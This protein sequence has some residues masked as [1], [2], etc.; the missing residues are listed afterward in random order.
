MTMMQPSTR[1]FSPHDQLRRR[2][3]IAV[4]R[5]RSGSRTHRAFTKE[6]ERL[7]ERLLAKEQDFIDN[8]AFYEKDAEKS[9]YDEAPDIQK[10]DTTWYHP[11]M[12]DL[13]LTRERN[14]KSGQV[15]LTG[16]EERVLFLQFNYARHRVHELQKQVWASAD[17]QPTE[18]Q[19]REMLHWHSIAE[20]LREQIAN[21]NL[22]LVLAMAKRTRMSEVDFADLVSEGNMALLRAVDKFD[23]GRGFK[24]S[25]YACRAILKA[26]SRQGMKLSKYRQRFPTDF[27]P[28]LQKSN[29]LETRRD[30]HEKETAAE[31]R[32][33]VMENRADLSD[34]E[35]TIIEHRFGLESQTDEKPMTLEQ[36]GQ[37]IGVTKER[38]RQIQ[39]KAL[40]KIRIQLEENYLAPRRSEE[41]EEG[42]VTGYKLN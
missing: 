3:A 26:F 24:F 41:P 17:R 28:K 22:A 35:R 8:D 33:I 23:C 32:Q 38:V 21:T 11:V 37:I 18:E 40:E 31:V 25:T 39:N 30:D 2:R 6:E 36:I 13:G 29:F 5:D 42:Q 7:L 15:L 9:I 14:E 12:D 4:K 34:I 10:P 27:D 16:A 20:R 1:T 19:A